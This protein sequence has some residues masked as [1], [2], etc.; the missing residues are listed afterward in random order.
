MN[1]RH[2]NDWLSV[3]VFSQIFN[4]NS[5][6]M[7]NKNSFLIGDLSIIIIIILINYIKN[8]KTSNNFMNQYDKSKFGFLG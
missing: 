7:K 8:V 2:N 4:E 6:W 1:H 3:K 5:F